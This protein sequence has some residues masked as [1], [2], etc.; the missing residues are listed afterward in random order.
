MWAL[1]H[2]NPEFDPQSHEVM[3][4]RLKDI[5]GFTDEELRFIISHDTA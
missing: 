2:E 5:Y 4:E 1:D 3:R